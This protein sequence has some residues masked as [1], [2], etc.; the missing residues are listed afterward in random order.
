MI[1]MSAIGHLKD[2]GGPAD[3]FFGREGNFIMN[4]MKGAAEFRRVIARCPS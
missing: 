3:G 4:G 2:L 1:S